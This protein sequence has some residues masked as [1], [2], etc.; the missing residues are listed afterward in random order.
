MYLVSHYPKDTSM[1]FLAGWILALFWQQSGWLAHDF[2]HNQVFSNRA[3]SRLFGYM[4]GNVWQGFSVAWWNNKHL[5]HHA[6]P[7]INAEDPDID[8]FPVLAWSDH[9]LSLFT[10]L[11][12]DA[13]SR[14]FIKYQAW[15]FFPVLAL[16]RI[17]WA[18]QSIF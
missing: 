10:D 12:D 6:V 8:T 11:S 18:M 5:A 7:N 4:I 17:S 13:A 9:A 1:V 15:Y 3:T 2:L 14:F 16:A